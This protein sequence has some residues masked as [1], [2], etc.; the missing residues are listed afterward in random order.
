MPT[1]DQNLIG[2]FRLGYQNGAE[3]DATKLEWTG[4]PWPDWLR[5]RYLKDGA[6]LFSLGEDKNYKHWFD[7]LALL[8]QFDIG[9]DITFRARFLKSPDFQKS[10]SSGKISYTEFATVPDRGILKRLWCTVNPNAQFG[11]NT[12]TNL[13]AID[14]QIIAIGDLPK[15]MAI[16]PD[17]LATN[18]EWDIKKWTLLTSTPHP[19]RDEARKAWYNL[20]IG[21]TLRGFG[22]HVYCLS[23]GSHKPE[24]ITF[25]PRSKPAYMHSVAMTERYMVVAEHPMYA[26]L[27]KFF[28]L[29]IRNQPIINAFNWNGDKPLTFFIIDKA[30]KK[31][32]A[33]VEAPAH[34]YFHSTNAYE[35]GDDVVI[36]LCT[37][38]DDKV[39]KKL[40]LDYINSADGGETSPTKLIRHR[41]NLK[42]KKLSLEQLTDASVEFPKSNP[43]VMHKEYR[44][45]YAVGINP[46]VPNDHT[47]QLVKVDVASG[48]VKSWFEP[49][50]YPN[51]P[52]MVPRPG[53]T[54]EDDGIILCV[55]LDAKIRSSVLLML[56]AQSFTE[57]GRALIP[58]VIPFGLHGQVAPLNG[59]KKQESGVPLH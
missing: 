51:E 54:A 13:Q 10:T 9:D 11:I 41:I 37:Y 1:T 47:N 12:A 8:K 31:L 34:F 57:I 30:E 58:M 19:Q 32:A 36:D 5:L 16:D 53:A 39:I 7:G 52:F 17:T 49:G 24:P 59:D 23:D 15:G 40:Y 6:G 20:G 26:S 38:P 43:H 21:M 46:A 55:V 2:G 18:E 29:G 45:T 33:R 42:T 3:Q 22:Y 44:Y 25:I 4:S 27:A 56:D 35:D 14:G 28:T 50:C 48:D